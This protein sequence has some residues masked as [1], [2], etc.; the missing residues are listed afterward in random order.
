MIDPYYIQKVEGWK[1]M[2]HWITTKDL[3]FKEFCKQNKMD[4]ILFSGYVSFLANMVSDEE[5]LTFVMKRIADS[6]EALQNHIV[7]IE[8]KKLNCSHQD[9]CV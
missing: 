2:I 4:Y 3:S 1:N 8:K 7:Y 6:E 5:R 9:C